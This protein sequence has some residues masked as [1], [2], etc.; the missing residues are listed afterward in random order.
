MSKKIIMMK[1]LPASGKSTWAREM[2]GKK[3]GAYKIVNKDLL[4]TMLDAGEWSPSKEKLI[5]KCRDSVINMAVKNGYSIIVDDTNLPPKHEENLRCIAEEHGVEF[6]VKDL[7]DVSITECLKRDAKRANPVGPEVIKRM[8]TQFL[9][10]SILPAKWDINLPV[11]FQCDLDGTLAIH[12]G[13]SPYDAA[14]CGSDSLNIRLADMLQ[15][16]R[17]SGQEVIFLTGREDTY[18]EQTQQWLDD[19]HFGGCKLYMRKGGDSRKDF[20]VKEEM[21]REHIEG[22]YSVAGV[23]DDRAQVCRMWHELG[24][25]LFRVGDPDAEF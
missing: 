5:V 23:F 11:I 4:R 13:R 3:K 17:S 2:L 9:A 25:P 21:Y 15:L 12:N 22:I 10:K 18:R 14:S 19:N 8:Y 6:E 20:V 1:G 16:F 24:L 7:T